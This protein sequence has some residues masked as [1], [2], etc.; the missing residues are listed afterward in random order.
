MHL[1]DTFPPLLTP[2]YQRE[3]DVGMAIL[4]WSGPTQSAKTTKGSILSFDKV[5]WSG[6]GQTFDDICCFMHFGSDILH[7]PTCSM[8]CW[9]APF[10]LVVPSSYCTSHH[11]A[12]GNNVCRSIH[13]GSPLD[14]LLDFPKQHARGIAMVW[15]GQMVQ[16]QCSGMG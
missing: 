7:V 1:F 5:I 6:S 2:M 13:R 14:H 12:L 3:I 8:C 15:S 9:W 10:L 4:Y 16:A 11:K